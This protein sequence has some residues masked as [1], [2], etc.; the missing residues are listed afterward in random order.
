M[1]NLS[2]G[3]GEVGPNKG[4]YYFSYISYSRECGFVSQFDF[5]RKRKTD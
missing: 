5:R 4:P 1:Y 3:H 2:C